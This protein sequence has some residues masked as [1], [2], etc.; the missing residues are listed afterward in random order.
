MSS[1]FS[2]LLGKLFD[3]LWSIVGAV[4]TAVCTMVNAI[5]GWVWDA[6]WQA[7]WT[8]CDGVWDMVH[9][10]WN[11]ACGAGAS[12]LSQY[13]AKVHRLPFVRSECRSVAAVLGHGKLLV[14][15]DGVLYR[16]GGPFYLLGY[17]H[18]V[19]VCMAV[20]SGVSLS[21]GPVWN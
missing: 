9:T 21:E 3:V 14:A 13:L 6:L 16:D 15:L 1:F 19:Q 11:W 8:I 4:W 20:G 10:L 2:G 18:H 5:S 12:F 7:V 17:V